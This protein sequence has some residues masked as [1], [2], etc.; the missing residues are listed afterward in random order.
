MSVSVPPPA[1]V[2]AKLR[3]NTQPL[4]L[5]SDAHSKLEGPLQP[6]GSVVPES[7]NPV[8]GSPS[9]DAKL[10]L[11]ARLVPIE[12]DTVPPTDP[13]ATTES[14]LP[15]ELVLPKSTAPGLD[16]FGAGGAAT[17]GAAADPLVSLIELAPQPESSAITNDPSKKGRK[18]YSMSLDSRCSWGRGEF[19]ASA[20]IKLGAVRSVR[21]QLRHAFRRAEL[22]AALILII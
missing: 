16:R 18:L 2:G 8:I 7:A 21:N 1:A 9:L 5:P 19:G 22:G 20:L 11:T 4:P 13:V 15:L 14:A 12:A 6:G 10:T 17:T 3:F